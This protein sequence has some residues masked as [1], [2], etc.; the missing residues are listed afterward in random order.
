MDYFT[1]LLLDLPLNQEFSRIKRGEELSS[2]NIPY[3][4]H[5]IDLMIKYFELTEKYESCEILLDFKNNKIRSH[6]LKWS[7]GITV[8]TDLLNNL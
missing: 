4:T 3:T 5:Y 6:N 1:K 2:S 7:P 8:E